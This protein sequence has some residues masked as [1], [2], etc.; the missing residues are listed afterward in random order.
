[1]KF[2][3][4]KILESF[5]Q[6]THK[7]TKLL[8]LGGTD[9]K[10]HCYTRSNDE[11][12]VYKFELSGHENAITKLAITQENEGYLLASSSKDGYIRIWRFTEN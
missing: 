6:I 7:N 12:L 4:N 2:P 8:L 9:Q 3:L 5:V 1:M 10:I 11:S